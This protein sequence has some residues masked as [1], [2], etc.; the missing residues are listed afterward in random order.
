MSKC[1]SF[2]VDLES[3]LDCEAR[4]ADLESRLASFEA[5]VSYDHRQRCKRMFFT[6]SNS[7][8][9]T[10]LDSYYPSPQR[11]DEYNL[12]ISEIW[13]FLYDPFTQLA[14][15]IPGFI[16]LVA[17]VLDLWIYLGVNR[18]FGGGPGAP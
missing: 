10:G 14:L 16:S 17:V 1:T 18:V 8:T 4:L 9:N 2:E 3:Q 5:A 15:C 13:K 11:Y 6:V 7:C 12:F